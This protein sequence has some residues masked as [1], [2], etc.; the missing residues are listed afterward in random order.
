MSRFTDYRPV[1]FR[2]VCAVARMVLLKE[3]AMNDAD[4]K[5]ATLEAL[6]KQGW[7]NPPSDML[8]RALSA[9]EQAL[10]QTIGQRPVPDV[11]PSDDPIKPE[12][13]PPTREEWAVIVETIKACAAR[14]EA[15]RQSKVVPLAR[16][17]STL[18]EKAVI[19]EFYAEANT[20]GFDKLEILKRFAELAIERP[21]DWDYER[22]RAEA[23][24]H[25]LH[26]KS[27]FG[28]GSQSRTL[29]WHHIIQIQHGGSNYLRN[30]V[31]ICGPC[32]SAVHPWLPKETRSA[33]SWSSFMDVSPAIFA[34]MERYLKNRR[35][36]S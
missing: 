32:H 23:D 7:D 22:V 28:C 36:A 31:A 17:T 8:A 34:M 10:K 15:M 11:T 14:T 12:V 4:W 13:P 27:C 25:S 30:R 1:E 29:N 16:E 5:H 19:D 33:G 6:A 20:P 21:D 24:K 2:Q 35:D 9:V 3:P 18:S 26:A